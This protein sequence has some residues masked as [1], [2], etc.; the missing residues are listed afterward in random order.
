M[1]I[2]CGERIPTDS[3]KRTYACSAPILSLVDASKEQINREKEEIAQY[4]EN[5]I[6]PDFQKVSPRMILEL[7]LDIP[8][9]VKTFLLNIEMGI[10]FMATTLSSETI[11]LMMIMDMGRLLLV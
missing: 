11:E 1:A 8:I 7:L 4:L 6:D 9:F 2:G 10:Q 3:W 5:K